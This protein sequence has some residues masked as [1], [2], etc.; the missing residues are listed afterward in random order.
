[1]GA[2][3]PA[4]VAGPRAAAAVRGAGEGVAG[5]PVPAAVTQSVTAVAAVSRDLRRVLEGN[6]KVS[7]V[8]AVKRARRGCGVRAPA[9]LQ[10]P[11]MRGMRTSCD[12]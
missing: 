6:T 3:A 12:V 11:T 10:A 7:C 9:A 1:M 2:V 5:Y 8:G 4:K